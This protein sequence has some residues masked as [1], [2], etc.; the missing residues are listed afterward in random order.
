MMAAEAVALPGDLVTSWKEMCERY[1]DQ[2]VVLV[3]TDWL[4]R[5]SLDFRSARVVG[6]GTRAEADDVADVA[7]QQYGGI[8]VFF[9]GRIKAPFPPILILPPR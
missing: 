4:T 3:E 6:H 1:P 2:W 8:G 7:I 9:T 5:S